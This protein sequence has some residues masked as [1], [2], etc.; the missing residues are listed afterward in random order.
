MGETHL[1]VVLLSTSTA[2]GTVKKIF[3]FL[4]IADTGILRVGENI[5][6][7]KQED[8]RSWRLMWGT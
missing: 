1:V 4:Y 8:N 3:A 6:Q 5:R 7:V 2:T